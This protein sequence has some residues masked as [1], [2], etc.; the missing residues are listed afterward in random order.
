MQ[1]GVI[2]F[3]HCLADLNVLC[4]FCFLQPFLVLRDNVMD[5]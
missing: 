2:F 5:L 1:Y 3:I 4:K